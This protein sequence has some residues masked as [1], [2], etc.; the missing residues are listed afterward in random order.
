MGIGK[1]GRGEDSAG[2]P[3]PFR[4][5]RPFRGPLPGLGGPRERTVVLVQSEGRLGV[6]PARPTSRNPTGQQRHHRQGQ[7]HHAEGE[8]VPGGHI[9][10]EAGQDSP[11]GEGTENSQGKG[12]T[13]QDHPLS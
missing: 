10:E 8:W 13:D 3:G 1:L 5:P 6:H 12:G 7:G 9:V 4:G 11:N 2:G